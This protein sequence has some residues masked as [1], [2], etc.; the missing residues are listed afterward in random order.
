MGDVGGKPVDIRRRHSGFGQ[1][2]F[3]RFGG[4]FVGRATGSAFHPSFT[5]GDDPDVVA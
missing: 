2:F 1:D 3:K 4:E 5:I